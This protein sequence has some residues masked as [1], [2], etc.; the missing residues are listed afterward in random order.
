MDNGNRWFTTMIFHSCLYV[1]QM[2]YHNLHYI[3]IVG[4]ISPCYS[5]FFQFS[6]TSPLTPPFGDFPTSPKILNIFPFSWFS[7]LSL[8][9]SVHRHFPFIVC[10]AG[11]HMFFHMCRSFPWFSL[12]FPFKHGDLRHL[13]T[14]KNIPRYGRVQRSCAA[15]TEIPSHRS[16]KHLKRDMENYS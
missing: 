16:G 3:L 8:S 5:M 9:V 1:Y 4:I 13:S 2:V 7:L 6:M 14:N 15:R 12:I 10:W 11:F